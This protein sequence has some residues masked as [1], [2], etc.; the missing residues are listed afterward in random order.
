MVEF[1]TKC[2]HCQSI[3][4]V[5]D[6]WIGMEVECPACQKNFTVQHQASA[7]P[8]AELG[9]SQTFTFVCPSCDAVAELPVS[10]LGQKYECQMC[11]EEHIAQATTEKQCPVCGQTIKY[12]ATVCKYC[13]ADL[14]KLPPGAG[15]A[16]KP[17]QEGKFI[18]ICQECDTVAELPLSEKGQEYTCKA[19]CE[20]TIA[21]PSEE[22]KCPY[23]GEKIKIKA[24]VCK[25]C[26]KNVPPIPIVGNSTTPTQQGSAFLQPINNTSTNY[27]AVPPARF[28]P[29]GCMANQQ[30][31]S[32][33][34]V[35]RIN[36]LNKT[37]YSILFVINTVLFIIGIFI[38]PILILAMLITAVVLLILPKEQMILDRD[39]YIL[40][41]TRLTEKDSTEAGYNY[42]S[43]TQYFIRLTNKR[44]ILSNAPYPAMSALSAVIID[45]FRE[46]V[47]NT[48]YF[49]IPDIID[50]GTAI[51]FN[52]VK[53]IFGIK[54]R[55]KLPTLT[56]HTVNGDLKFIGKNNNFNTVLSWWNKSKGI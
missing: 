37:V 49:D 40:G 48:V 35:D 24:A 6:D 28:S 19:C 18:F 21:Q 32:Q 29:S 4:S 42:F 10:L 20:T 41:K 46:P 13:K 47:D 55:K 43:S 12:H 56:L 27:T 7:P 3:L 16:A 45:N 5:Q 9:N 2:P 36:Q 50:I 14:T 54:Y 53:I 22:R 52:E 15:N 23:C 51:E 17:A 30:V 31:E 38:W 33:E 44:M 39:E 25:H 1:E 8:P 34:E 11:F 26:K